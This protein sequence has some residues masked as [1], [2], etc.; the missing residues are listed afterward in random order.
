MGTNDVHKE[1]QRAIA[2]VTFSRGYAQ[3][4]TKLSSQN[5]VSGQVKCLR[6]GGRS[7]H[8]RR[9]GRGPDGSGRA[10]D[11]RPA[12]ARAIASDP[13][14]GQDPVRYYPTW[15]FMQYYSTGCK[16]HRESTVK[17]ASQGVDSVDTLLDM[18]KAEADLLRYI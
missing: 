8:A 1:T 7:E 3:P 13:R 4:S 15:Y 6:D 18:V 5:S 14:S 10:T 2:R 12:R 17:D 11:V 9:P 16:K